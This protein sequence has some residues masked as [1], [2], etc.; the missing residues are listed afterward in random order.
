MN[1]HARLLSDLGVKMI[2]Q[3]TD[4][5]REMFQHTKAK[6]RAEWTAKGVRFGECR[7]PTCGTLVKEPT[8]ALCPQC[9]RALAIVE[10]IKGNAA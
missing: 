1:G 9:R 5:D 8:S 10:P 7:G 4:R 6:L 3:L 2:R